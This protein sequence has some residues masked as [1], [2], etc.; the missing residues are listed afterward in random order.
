MSEEKTELIDEEKNPEPET[1]EE[2]PKPKR[3]TKAEL[4]KELAELKHRLDNQPKR[5]FTITSGSDPT[6]S[7]PELQT[8]VKLF[9]EF[10]MAPT[11]REI[12]ETIRPKYV[13]A[14][15]RLKRFAGL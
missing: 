7:T 12:G 2:P 4:E 11:Q 15:R 5:A 1:A 8:I 9:P 13:A 10:P 14:L 6:V 3:K